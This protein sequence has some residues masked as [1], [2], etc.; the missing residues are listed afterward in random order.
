MDYL[1]SRRSIYLASDKKAITS[2][3]QGKANRQIKHIRSSSP[4]PPAPPPPP[5]SY[6]H[7][8]PFMSTHLVFFCFFLYSFF[9]FFLSSTTFSR[10][11]PFF[12]C[13]IG[14]LDGTWL[15]SMLIVHHGV[16][17]FCLS[18]SFVGLHLQRTPLGQAS[19]CK[20]LFPSRSFFFFVLSLFVCISLSFSSSLFLSVLHLL[21][22][23]PRKRKRRKKKEQR[24]NSVREDGEDQE[25]HNASCILSNKQCLLVCLCVLFSF[26][27]PFLF[28][29]S[30]L[31]LPRLLFVVVSVLSSLSPF[32]PPY[33][34]EL[35]R[36]WFSPHLYLFQRMSC[37]LGHCVCV[38]C[39]CECV[40]VFLFFIRFPALTPYTND[41]TWKK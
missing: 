3:H 8:P 37:S 39:V 13:V 21:C 6:L 15:Y 18:C 19:T 30:F 27:T 26:P 36:C 9:D 40:C 38:W 5:P 12:I 14:S 11:F 22:I 4:P 41:T 7:L 33:L 29:L 25:S 10:V 16:I 32:V 28:S 34:R 24:N 35:G 1:R 23:S 31:L 2:T 17:C 20:S